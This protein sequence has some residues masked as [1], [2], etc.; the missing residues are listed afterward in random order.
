MV[1]Y[2]PDDENAPRTHPASPDPFGSRAADTHL[3]EE[4]DRSWASGCLSA[5]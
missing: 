4:V 3:S 2:R 5:I 1:A